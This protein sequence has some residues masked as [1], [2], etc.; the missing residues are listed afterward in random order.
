MIAYVDILQAAC[1]FRKYSISEEVTAH[2]GLFNA[3]TK[4]YH[5]DV[6]DN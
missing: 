1:A 3:P 5:D 6:R 4:R 2:R